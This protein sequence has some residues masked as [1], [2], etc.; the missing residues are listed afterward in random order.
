MS[1]SDLVEFFKPLFANQ[2]GVLFI[3]SIVVISAVAF[4][5]VAWREFLS[6]YLR[7]QHILDEMT[8]L[9]TEVVM[10]KEQLTNSS[11]FTALGNASM[12]E[13]QAANNAARMRKLPYFQEEL[14][15]EEGAP[16]VAAPSSP[17]KSRW[18]DVRIPGK[19]KPT[20]FPIK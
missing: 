20:T 12:A 18:F 6:W 5:F 10:L 15:S 1:Y 11:V 8:R 14:S 7:T 9:R 4:L 2:Q 19:D 17:V 3:I 16:Q 13:A